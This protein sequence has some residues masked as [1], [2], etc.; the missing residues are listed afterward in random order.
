MT[1]QASLYDLILVIS[2]MAE[3]DRR[4]KI[5]SD[6]E[7]QIASGGGALERNDDWNVRPLTYEIKHQREG[8]Y[9]LLQFTGPATLLDDIS[10][11]LRIDDAVL[12]FRIIK[13]L[14]GTPAPPD[15][16]P[17]VVAAAVPAEA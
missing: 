1:K 4:A 5:L 7:A 16:A 2:M 17:P 12:R 15:S 8:A 3:E 13:V 11:T 9:H 6:V 10:H 14:P